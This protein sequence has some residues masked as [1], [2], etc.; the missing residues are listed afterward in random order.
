M[1]KS[2]TDIFDNGEWEYTP[3]G[4]CYLFNDAIML[5]ASAGGAVPAA[6]VSL[7]DSPVST[8][9]L[10]AYT[11]P[12]A[13]IGSA[14]ANRI[15]VVGVGGAT[16]GGARTISSV[17]I[18]GVSAAQVIDH[19]SANAGNHS[20]IWAAA[21]PTGTTADI[22]VTWSAGMFNCGIG[23]WAAYDC[24][25]T[26][27]HTAQ[28]NVTASTSSLFVP[29]GGIGI[30]YFFNGGGS[31]TYTWTGL[32]EDF[33]EA[34]DASDG[35]YHSGASLAFDTEQN[36]LAIAA[37]ASGGSQWAHSVASF[38]PLDTT[39]FY[40]GPGAFKNRNEE[41]T[42]SGD[43][44]A[45][46]GAEDGMRSTF[47]FTGDFV[48]RWTP[49]VTGGSYSIGVFDEADLGSYTPDGSEYCGVLQNASYDGF[50]IRNL[51]T[52]PN[53]FYYSKNTQEFTQSSTTNEHRIERVGSTITF[54]ENDTLRATATDTSSASM[55]L[56]MGNGG[57][58]ADTFQDF[59]WD[60]N[61]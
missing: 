33:D 61:S 28:D 16:S 51:A 13:A 58:I 30:G 18:G 40:G 15:V 41:F 8:S 46:A 45:Q 22:V 12:S 55:F 19:S 50:S 57:T 60:D 5:G 4:R 56:C 38:G 27:S 36:L 44:I 48:I 29:E 54:Y 32:T 17:T 21:V 43:D 1:A 53:E 37:T 6:T 39:T 10:T 2:V 20:K 7:T 35:A 59:S 25:I 49:A 3:K 52:G 26:A 9:N 31:S 24:L 23:V 14:D 34:V 42:F 11:F 47:K